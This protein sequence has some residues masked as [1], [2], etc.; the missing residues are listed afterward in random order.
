VRPHDPAPNG[1]EI[2]SRFTLLDASFNKIVHAI[3]MER[4]HM[5]ARCPQA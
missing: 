1:R 3:Y 2:G 4:L 5:P